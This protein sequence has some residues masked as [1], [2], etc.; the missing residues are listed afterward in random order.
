MT[1]QMTPHRPLARLA[2][3]APDLYLMPL[4]RKKFPVNSYARWDQGKH[5]QLYNVTIMAHVGK[6]SLLIRIDKVVHALPG[7]SGVHLYKP[8]QTKFVLARN[9]SKI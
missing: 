5:G 8:G 1:R 9:L 3:P 2:S 6:R 7:G 4:M